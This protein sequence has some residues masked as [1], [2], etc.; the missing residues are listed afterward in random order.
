AQYRLTRELVRVLRVTGDHVA[1]PVAWNLGARPF[2]VY[3]LAEGSLRDEMNACFRAGKVYH[4][5][6]ALGRAFQ[7]LQGLCEAHGAGLIH[8]DVKPDNYLMYRDGVKLTDFGVGR[9]LARGR[10]SQTCWA[11]GTPNYSAPEQRL[12]YSVDGRADLYSVGVVLYEMLMGR[13]P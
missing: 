4:P 13:L 1:R 2:A 5:R 11:V 9:T 8:R 7:M 3:E 10:G 12:G 6:F